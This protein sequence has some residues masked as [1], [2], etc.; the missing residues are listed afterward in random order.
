MKVDVKNET[1]RM[2]IVYTIQYL[3]EKLARL[4]LL[5]TGVVDNIILWSKRKAGIP[6]LDANR[7]IT[8]KQNLKNQRSEPQTATVRKFH[9]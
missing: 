6:T 3:M 2:A 5:H 1:D 8:L 4:L 7:R 9:Y